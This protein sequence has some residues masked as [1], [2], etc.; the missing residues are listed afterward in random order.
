MQDGIRTLHPG[1]VPSLLELCG[2][3]GWNQTEAD[4][5]RLF[6][7][8]PGGCFGSEADGR[9]VATATAVCYGRDLA[10][11]GMVLT[12]P[13]YRGRGLGS[14]LT[15]AAVEAAGQSGARSIKL[16]AT[17]MGRPVYLKLGFLDEAPIERWAAEAPAV[18][19]ASRGI[20]D[21]AP[22]FAFD[23]TLDRT[24]FGADRSALVATLAGEYSRSVPGRGY[25]APRSGARAVQLGPCVARDPGTARSLIAWVLASVPGRQVYWDLLPGNRAA[26]DM[27]AGLGFAPARTLVRMRLGGAAGPDVPHQDSLVWATAGFEYG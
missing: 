20:G 17:D 7:L 24:A 18:A 27:A 16:D 12:S 22:R 25:I 4:W 19:V 5:L 15:A 26:A 13:A 3:A 6:A 1:D 14:R 21:A 11:I 8:A 9:I 23:A 2:E 10:W